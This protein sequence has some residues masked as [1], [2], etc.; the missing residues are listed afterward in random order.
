MIEAL[1]VQTQPAS[2]NIEMERLAVQKK[3]KTYLLI[4]YFNY[5]A[6]HRVMF[7]KAVQRTIGAAAL[8]LS[9][10]K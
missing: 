1:N 9:E 4:F 8:I 6:K 7:F 10:A 5:L 2:L 3:S